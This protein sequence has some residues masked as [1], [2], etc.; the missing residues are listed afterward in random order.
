MPDHHERLVLASS[1]AARRRVLE[2][3]GIAHEVIAPDVDED[4]MKLA[5]GVGLDDVEPGDVAEVLA[6]A[7]AENVSAR[8]PGRW[9]LAGDQ[10]LACDGVMY[11][12][13]DTMAA[14]RDQLL[15]L[16]GK[17]HRLYSAVVLAKDGAVEW[18]AVAMADVTFRDL[19]AA[20]VGRYLGTVGDAALT[21]V[22]GYQMEGPGIQLMSEVNGDIFTVLGMP[23]FEVMPEL[24]ARGVLA[25]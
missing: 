5:L 4:A 8:A 9:V 24:R 15:T 1:S 17:T 2:N 19:S 10:I 23:L 3:A 12:K 14:A 11:F 18:S 7:K 22:G 13:P 16:R 20:F 21:S 25:E 6:R